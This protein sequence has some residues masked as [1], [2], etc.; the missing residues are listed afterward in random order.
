[1]TR[2]RAVL[3]AAGAVVWAAFSANAQPPAAPAAPAERPAAAT[4]VELFTA[5]GCAG[6]PEANE[7][8]AAAAERDGVLVLSWSVD[9]WDY[10]GWRDT[11][12]R[13]E[14]AARQRSYAAR[15]SRRRL[16]TPQVVVNGAAASTGADAAQ[17]ERLIEL[18]E[19]RPRVDLRLAEDG[20]RV[21]IG[22]GRA[23]AGGAEVWLVRYDP[24]P[25]AVA[26]RT[27]ENRGLELQA[28]NSVR[29]LVRLGGWRGRPERLRLPA[30][31]DPQLRTAVVLQGAEG[32]P[33][34]GFAAD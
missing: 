22:S 16:S 12:A 31:D 21:W 11:L 3:V 20:S 4:L 17:L 19:A 30:A 28:P 18:A 10:L 8:L 33:V 29:Q 27:G 5:Q 26:V 13:P 14:F 1:M 32:G 34:L 23:P 15:L 6:C 25:E 24:D 7:R 9:Y 2:L